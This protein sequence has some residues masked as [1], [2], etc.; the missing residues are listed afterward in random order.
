[1]TLRCHCCHGGGIA[2]TV[3]AKRRSRPMDARIDHVADAPSGFTTPRAGGRVL[4]TPTPDGSYSATRSALP[5]P[6]GGATDAERAFFTENYEGVPM[7]ELLR[8][9]R[10]AEWN[11]D[12]RS[13][14]AA[15]L[16]R[17]Q[18]NQTPEYRVQAMAEALG[19]VR[20]L[21]AVP[22]RRTVP[23]AELN[24]ALDPRGGSPVS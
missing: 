4:L 15:A 3:P 5:D 22:R 21:L 11:A 7:L 17:S 18:K 2:E 13:Q 10:L 23:V 6:L 19:K 14:E 9:L 8:R 20:A 16:R 12:A 24:A 1:M